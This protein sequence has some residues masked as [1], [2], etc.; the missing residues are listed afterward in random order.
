[1]YRADGGCGH[2]GFHGPPRPLA[3]GVERALLVAGLGLLLVLG[4]CSSSDDDGSSSPPLGQG[5]PA[6]VDAASDGSPDGPDG[7][8]DDGSAVLAVGPDLQIS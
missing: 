7:A 1:M 3:E 8:I 6:D 4:G 5:G 2:S